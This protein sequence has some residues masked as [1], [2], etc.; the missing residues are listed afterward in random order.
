MP[1]WSPD[2]L[3]IAY[4]CVSNAQADI[5]VKN[6]DGSGSE[7][8]LTNHPANDN[9]PSWSPD[10][11]AIVFTSERGGGANVYVMNADGT[12]VS[13]LTAV[14][15]NH[16]EP[17]WGITVLAQPLGGPPP[18]P[19]SGLTPWGLLALAAMLGGLLLWRLL[20]PAR[21]QFEGLESV[22]ETM[23]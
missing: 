13:A 6:A 4:D 1:S 15:G 18:T 9:D 5:C 10:G 17:S 21:S 16:L 8:T 2:G 19:I 11:K 23:F 7:T 12:G 20:V 3:K 22:R 14:S